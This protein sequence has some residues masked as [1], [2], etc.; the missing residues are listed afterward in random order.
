MILAID[1]GANLGWARFDPQKKEMEACGLGAKPIQRLFEP[2]PSDYPDRLYT[3]NITR[4]VIE[5]PHTG[6]SRARARDIIT[7]AVRAGEVGGV[8]RYLLKVEPEYIEPVRWKG[9]MEKKICNRAVEAKL[10]PQEI[11]ILNKC[12]NKSTRHN[13]LD[14][15]GIGLFCVGRF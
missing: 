7:L 4:I 8:L 5:R 10:L 15:I 1:S 12:G 13:I 14:A 2:Q 3:R 9:S 6:R 11:Q